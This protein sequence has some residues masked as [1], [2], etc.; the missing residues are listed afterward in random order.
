MLRPWAMMLMATASVL[1]A[2]RFDVC[3][4][5]VSVAAV[6]LD[7]GW[8]SSVDG[9]LGVDLG[10]FGVIAGAGVAHDRR[11]PAEGERQAT[12]ARLIAGPYLPLG[13]TNVEL[14]PWIGCGRAAVT[15]AWG[16]SGTTPIS[17][18]GADLLITC[19]LGHVVLGGGGGWQRA[20]DLEGGAWQAGALLGMRF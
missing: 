18:G 2:D 13:P 9:L 20:S 3:D 16:H 11:V 19:V 14:L 1:G 4:L 12:S 6:G 8:R 17:E 5:R 7:H 15:T 10:W